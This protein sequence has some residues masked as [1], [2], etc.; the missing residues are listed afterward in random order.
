[1]HT[2]S[3]KKKALLS[4]PHNV[5]SNVRFSFEISVRTDGKPI[6]NTQLLSSWVCIIFA[7]I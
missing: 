2:I 1:M 5:N 7:Y 6:V 3:I 4:L